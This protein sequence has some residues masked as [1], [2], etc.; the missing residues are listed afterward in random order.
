MS[1]KFKP[2]NLEI[3][4]LDEIIQISTK[5]FF[6][7]SESSVY[8]IELLNDLSLKKESIHSFK[9]KKSVRFKKLEEGF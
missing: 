2:L 1:E 8:T 9:S 3:E 7:S 4:T 6:L 5:E